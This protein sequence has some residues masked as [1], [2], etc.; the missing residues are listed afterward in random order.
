ML[1]GIS[2]SRP[3]QVTE[4]TPI[5]TSP[6]TNLKTEQPLPSTETV[7]IHFSRF[8]PT[9]RFSAILPSDWEVGYIPEIQAIYIFDPDVSASSNVEK[10]QLFIRQ[11]RANTFLTLGTVTVLDTK[12]LVIQGHAAKEYRIQ[13]KSTVR[14]FPFQPT[15]RNEEHLVTDI[16]FQETEN[17]LF[18]VFAQQPGINTTTA[19]TFFASLQFD[20]DTTSTLSHEQLRVE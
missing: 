3:Q 13:K 12:E 18:Y 1:L 19:K 6:L 15:W 14:D 10:S 16:R 7:R 20:N 11:F 2:C 17:S 9:F 5:I 8:D 4:D